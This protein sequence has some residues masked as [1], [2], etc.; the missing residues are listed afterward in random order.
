MKIGFFDSGLGGLTVLKEALNSGINAD[1]IYLADIKNTPYGIKDKEV[2]KKYIFNNIDYLVKNECEII[3]IA[4]NTATAICIDDLRK[5]YKNI[6]FIG[7]E[8]ALKVAVD[9]NNV[10]NI[11][12]TATTNTLKQKKLQNLILNL[13]VKDKVTLLA[14]DKLVYFAENNIDRS[15]VREY[16]Y[17]RLNQYN[18][19]T[20]SHIVLGCTHFPIYRDVFESIAP[21]N[22]KIIDGSIG[23][24]KN[25]YLKYNMLAVNKP[26]NQTTTFVVTKNSTTFINS[27]KKILNREINKIIII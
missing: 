12:I 5:K 7:T 13:N 11:L 6:I 22:V 21:V 18:L 19:K 3:V 9:S 1:F 27:A 20:Y 8:P 25:L 4:C 17:D 2:V 14:L 16:L 23:I 26:L 24:V 15:I 10:K